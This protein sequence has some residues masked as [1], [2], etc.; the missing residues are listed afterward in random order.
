MERI[1]QWFELSGETPRDRIRENPVQLGALAVVLW[2]G[3][4]VA[5]FSLELFMGEVWATLVILLGAIAVGFHL[6]DLLVPAVT[7]AE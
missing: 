7:E 5:Y 4:F 2:I 6:R 3:A 1:R